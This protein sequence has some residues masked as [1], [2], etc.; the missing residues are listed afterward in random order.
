[1]KPRTATRKRVSH[2]CQYGKPCRACRLSKRVPVT[3]EALATLR[4]AL[5][6]TRRYRN[7]EAIESIRLPFNQ[8]GADAYGPRGQ[9]RFYTRKAYVEAGR[10]N[11]LAWQ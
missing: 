2:T 1:V 10:R 4:S 11:G 3:A 6:S 8:P 5:E 9:Q 7:Q